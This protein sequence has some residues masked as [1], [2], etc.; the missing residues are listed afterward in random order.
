MRL[1]MQQPFS[2]LVT[3][4]AVILPAATA[5]NVLRSSS[6]AACQG[7][8]GFTASL[9]DVIF[10]PNNNTV[11]INMIATST[12]EGFVIFDVTIRAYGYPFFRETIDPCDSGFPGLCP[13]TSGEMNYPMH[14]PVG[15]D[16]SRQI[17]GIAYSFPDLD[18]TVKVFVNLTSGP[19]AGTSVACVEANI[20][21][22][23]TVDLIGVKWA[24][25]A[26]A[27]LALIA[28]AV[29]SGLGYSNAAS[30]VAANALSLFGYFQAQAMVGLV[31]IPLPPAVMSWTQNFQW[32]MG[33][34]NVDFIQTIVT[35]YQRSTGGTASTIFDSLHT[36]SVQVEKRSVELVGPTRD[37]IQRSVAPLIGRAVG[38]AK[39]ANI[40]TA[41]GSYIV[42]GI[43]RVAFRAGIETT[44][45]FLTGLTFF[46]IF[47]LLTALA[48][49]LF[50]GFCELAA[51][52]GFIKGETFEDFRRGWLTM[53]KGIM[54]RVLLIG[55]P[56]MC[57]LCMWEFTQNDSPAAMVLAVFF[58]F[59]ILTSLGWAAFKVVSMAR[60]SVAL[61]RNHAY[62]LF[63]DPKALN[64]LGFLYVQFRASAYY[65]IVPILFYTLIKGMFIALAQGAG[66]VQA[67]ALIVLESAALITASV[68][69]PWMD[70]STNTFNIA[71]CSINFANAIFLF[72]FTDV[73]GLP[74]LVKGVVGV[75]LWIANAAFSLILLLFLIVTTGIVLFHNNPDTRYQFMNDD[76]MSFMKSQTHLQTSNQLEAL[77]ATARNSGRGFK[78]TLDL[79]EDQV[80]SMSSAQNMARP[81]SLHSA[82]NSMRQTNGDPSTYHDNHSNEKTHLRNRPS[83]HFRS[84]SPLTGSSSNLSHHNVSAA[85]GYRSST[86]PNNA[87]QWQRGAGYD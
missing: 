84:P 17:P 27:G 29:I 63:S 30:H 61:H 8:S 81:S 46:Y 19:N 68:M 22:G 31:G 53:L 40:Q 1:L 45:L 18:A 20:S 37:F 44:N 54:F 87:M 7:N 2:L 56:Q 67:V 73:L 71:I 60:R 25:A 52:L 58:F 70:K 82:R 66:T 5:E 57:I 14:L 23:K 51:R 21:N 64:K 69:R 34:I 38:L 13:M 15:A 32:T 47:A 16:A 28:S 74:P 36:V 78:P 50:K 85:V 10:T 39:R 9:F 48:V 26:V 3:Y 49:V 55:F 83:D 12:I 86:G 62:I 72:I 79:E 76:R 43:Q 65:F 11:A 4:L 6:L 35:W 77:A 41:Y 42:Y 75:V 24:T 59:G 80:S 33:I